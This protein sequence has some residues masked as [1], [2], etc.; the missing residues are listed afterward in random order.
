MWRD[1][2][3]NATSY[4]SELEGS[5]CYYIKERGIGSGIHWKEGR[6]E[7]RSKFSLGDE[8]KYQL[9]PFTQECRKKREFNL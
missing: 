4:V 8:G 5:G 9:Y 2:G 7:R 1:A 6:D 3:N